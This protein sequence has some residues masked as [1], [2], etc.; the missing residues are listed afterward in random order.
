MADRVPNGFWDKASPEEHIKRLQKVVPNKITEEIP[1]WITS[2]DI[3]QQIG[4]F[5]MEEREVLTLQK[6]SF[7][8]PNRVAM[9]INAWLKKEKKVNL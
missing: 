5:Y 1:Y 6:Y 8:F 3:A 4:L 2:E 9:R 7:Q